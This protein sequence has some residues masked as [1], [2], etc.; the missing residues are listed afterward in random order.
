MLRSQ[1]NSEVQG[2]GLT[3]RDLLQI[4]GSGAVAV[5]LQNLSGGRQ[6]Q[7]GQAD[8]GP[9]F[10]QAK[11]CILIYKYGSPPQH[12]TFNPKPEA[13]V[14]IQGTECRVVAHAPQ[15]L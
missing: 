13:P 15:P 2:D 4:G 3:R 11:S 12:E 7:A 9:R 6:A 8:V 1:V 5:A 14:E 10:G